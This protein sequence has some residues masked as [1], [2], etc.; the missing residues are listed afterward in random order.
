MPR[1]VIEFNVSLTELPQ[2]RRLVAFLREIADL[3][4]E[5]PDPEL[6]ACV[7]RV[8]DDLRAMRD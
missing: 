2:F 6:S 4:D 7:D 1:R 3:A 8:H 5:R